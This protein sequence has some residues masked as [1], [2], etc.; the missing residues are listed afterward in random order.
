MLTFS[1]IFNRKL[2]IC[3]LLK[4]GS[5]ILKIQQLEDDVSALFRNYF[6]LHS[7]FLWVILFILMACICSVICMQ[8]YFLLPVDLG[9][10]LMFCITV[11]VTF[12]HSCHHILL[13]LTQTNL[14]SYCLV[15]SAKV[16]RNFCIHLSLK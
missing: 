14:H 7:Y 16:S 4:A 12:N 8:I 2:H 5:S 3:S 13:S 15:N 11:S 10:S 9:N 6:A 1:T